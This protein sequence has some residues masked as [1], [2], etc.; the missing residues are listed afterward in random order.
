MGA[1]SIL[2]RSH[3]GRIPCQSYQNWHMITVA[4]W[5]LVVVAFFSS[6]ALVSCADDDYGNKNEHI[7]DGDQYYAKF[8][9]CADSSIV[10][11]E[12][13]IVCDSPGAYYYGSGKYRNSAT[14]QA[15]DKAKLTVTLSIADDLPDDVVPYLFLSVQGYGTVADQVIHQGD[16]LCSVSGLSSSDGAACP[17]P[18]TSDGAGFLRITCI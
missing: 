12:I 6:P 7:D 18:G 2:R 3:T 10:V 4:S 14:C 17:A 11:E 1:D 15:G 5:A 8:S 13:Q 16:D 9:V